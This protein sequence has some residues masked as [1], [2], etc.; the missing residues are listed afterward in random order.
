[1]KHTQ[2]PTKQKRMGT[3]ARQEALAGYALIAP[4]LIIY[5]VFPDVAGASVHRLE[6]RRRLR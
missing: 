6:L 1:M 5:T 4:N 2:P 3:L